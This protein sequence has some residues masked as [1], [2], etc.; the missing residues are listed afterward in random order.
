MSQVQN[1]LENQMGIPH[2]DDASETL[3]CITE[4]TLPGFGKETWASS[5]KVNNHIHI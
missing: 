3:Q 2:D 1:L 5:F 4:Q